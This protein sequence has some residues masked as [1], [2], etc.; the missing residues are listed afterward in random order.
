[1]VRRRVRYQDCRMGFA[2]DCSH[3]AGCILQKYELWPLVFALCSPLSVTFIYLM[4]SRFPS[5]MCYVYILLVRN[6]QYMASF[7]KLV[8]KPAMRATTFTYPK[9]GQQT[10]SKVVSLAQTQ[11]Q[12]QTRFL[13][14]LTDPSLSSSQRQCQTLCIIRARNLMTD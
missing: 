10:L 3:N 7:V 13:M 2:E 6:N 4:P 11:T 12:T 9:P 8:G 14:Y 1:M 5:V